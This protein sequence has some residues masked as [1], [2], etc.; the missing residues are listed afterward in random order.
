LQVF[1]NTTTGLLKHLSIKRI[2]RRRRTQ[3]EPVG[4]QEG[5]GLV[6]IAGREQKGVVWLE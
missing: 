1:R 6:D 3:A 5:A 4:E 2:P